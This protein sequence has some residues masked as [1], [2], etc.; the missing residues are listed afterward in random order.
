MVRHSF[1]NLLILTLVSFLGSI[2]TPAGWSIP[3]DVHLD[4]PSFVECQLVVDPQL[5]LDPAVERLVLVSVEIA[6]A[7][8]RERNDSLATLIVQARPWDDPLILHDFAPR[9]VQDSEI[10]GLVQV[11]STREHAANLGWNTRLPLPPAETQLQANVTGKHGETLRYQRKPEQHVLVSSG[12]FAR[13]SG[14]YF[15]FHRS[16][17][18][19]LEGTHGI[20]LILRVPA[21][22]RTS[23]LQ[24][25]ATA[26][27]ETKALLGEP[28]TQV[29]AQAT[30]LIPLFL[31]GDQE[32]RALAN[33][34][35]SAE[36]RFRQAATA[37][38][39][40]QQHDAWSNPFRGVLG[41]EPRPDLSP[42]RLEQL[43]LA[44]DPTIADRTHLPREVS[45]AFK[46]LQRRKQ[47]FVRL[48]TTCEQPVAT[49]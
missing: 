7:A 22:W 17:Q 44:S 1:R 30:F 48:A 2:V 32:A 12:F 36:Q 37:A 34:Y 40:K 5:P 10:E 46:E 9:N 43:L 15:K 8:K 49:R 47:Q 27:R 3:Q 33:A 25:Q 42:E 14:A 31:V 11:E 18:I 29:D 19:S 39:R 4:V 45:V 21:T 16:S 13:R 26:L 28:A 23:L 35:Q 6:A 38:I 20:T 41:Q 24:L